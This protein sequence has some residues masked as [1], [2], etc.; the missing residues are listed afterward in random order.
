M[1]DLICPKCKHILAGVVEKYRSQLLWEYNPQKKKFITT[2][3][4][5]NYDLAYACPICDYSL[6]AIKDQIEPRLEEPK[7]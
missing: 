5:L 6:D 1:A 7:L 4:S 2:K 3:D